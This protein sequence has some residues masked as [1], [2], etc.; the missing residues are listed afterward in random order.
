MPR[1]PGRA[2]LYSG[3]LS[4]R[5]PILGFIAV[6][7]WWFAIKP[8]TPEQGWV[9]VEQKFALCGE[10]SRQQACVVD[11]DTV[12]IGFG[13]NRR[14]IRLTGFNA[15][16]LDGACESESALARI[17]RARLHNWLNRGPF[18]WDGAHSPPRD[19]YGRELREARRTAADGSQESLAG[20][21]IH[22]GLASATGWGEYPRDWCAP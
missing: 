4:W 21:M 12:H 9:S 1:S 16:E 14:R 17:A 3:W 15:S 6:G 13:E 18:E 22:S 20:V 8:I 5:V 11:G 7:V 19:Q 10:G 2:T